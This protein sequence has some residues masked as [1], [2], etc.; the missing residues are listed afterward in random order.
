MLASTPGPKGALI[1]HALPGPGPGEWHGWFY[2]SQTSQTQEIQM[3]KSSYSRTHPGLGIRSPGPRGRMSKRTRS[4]GK[5][6]RR[7][8]SK[9]LREEKRS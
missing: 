5:E 4:L 3:P 9:V 7:K 1:I 6:E 8:E 2:E